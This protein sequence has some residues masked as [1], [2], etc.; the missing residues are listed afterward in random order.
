VEKC[1]HINLPLPIIS[2]HELWEDHFLHSKSAF[3]LVVNDFPI[4]LFEK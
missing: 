1:I 4:N 3:S 2:G